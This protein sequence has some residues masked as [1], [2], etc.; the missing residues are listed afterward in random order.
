MNRAPLFMRLLPTPW[1]VGFATLGPVGNLKRAPGTWGS[2][3][4][5]IIYALAF[6]Y[7]PPPLYIITTLVFVY[8]S[9]LVCNEAEVRLQQRDPGKIVLDECCAIPVCFFML[10]DA[11]TASGGWPLLLAGFALFRLFDIWKPGPIGRVQQVPGGLG[12]VLDDVLAGLATCLVLHL[13]VLAY[14][15]G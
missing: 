13:G 8:A 6:H 4:G 14:S 7:Q 15:L 11:V 10:Q 12:V 9:I 5:L 1:V 3:A 2:A